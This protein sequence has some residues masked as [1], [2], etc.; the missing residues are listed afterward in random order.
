MYIHDV[1]GFNPDNGA[2]GRGGKMS[3]GINAYGPYDDLQLNNNIV[4]YCDV[5]GIRN[6]VLAL[7][8]DTNTQFPAYM[9]NVSI[10][11][12][13][14][15]GVPGDG[16]VISSAN[17]PILQNNYLTDAGYSYHATSNAKT[18]N[19]SGWSAKSISSC[20]D[21]TKK[22]GTTA[23]DIS[24]RSKPT[25]MG[26]T[27]FAGLWFI[28]TKDA[29]A[30]YNEAVNNVWTC[31]DSEAFDAD[32]YCWGTIFQYNYTY[33]NNGGFCLF[34]STMKD[35]TIVRY[36]ISVEDAQSIGIGE[37]QNGTFHY[38]GAPEAIYNNLFILGNK[39][40]TMFGGGSDTT[41]FYNNIIIAPNGLTEST[42]FNGYHLN[43]SSDGEVKNPKLS[44]EIKNNIF[45]PAKIVES[46]VPGSTV[47]LENNIVL[48]NDDE[49]KALFKNLD[50]FMAAQPVKALAGRSDFMGSITVSGT[51][52]NGQPTNKGSGRA[53]T[54]AEARKVK[55]PTGGFDLNVFDGVKLADGSAA[56]GNGLAVFCYAQLQLQSPERGR[57]PVASGLLPQRHFKHDHG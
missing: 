30:Q 15:V 45:Y 27:N 47:D 2:V 11:N 53:M 3:G 26:S 1:V 54:D 20:R 21:V 6:D 10:S 8:T 5:E 50:S 23:R 19:S 46:I 7:M 56:I 51:D 9:E 29:V 31:N 49:M 14:I 55:T 41:Y 34:M 35:G 17:K 4:M 18:A 52:S 16:V 13:Y 37:S 48:K 32:M 43:G 40:A 28:G 44:G 22:T 42:S 36:N 25:V 24:D 57:Q 39:V 33:R 38:A 12:N